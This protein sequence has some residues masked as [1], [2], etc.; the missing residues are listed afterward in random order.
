MVQG[1]E[2]GKS[3][4]DFYTSRRDKRRASQAVGG[5]AVRSSHPPLGPVP[6]FPGLRVT[7][8]SDGVFRLVYLF[9]LSLCVGG[10]FRWILQEGG[11]TLRPC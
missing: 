2:L 6:S 7:D 5:Q 1:R 10:R 3:K 9:P 11:A 4:R 8:Y